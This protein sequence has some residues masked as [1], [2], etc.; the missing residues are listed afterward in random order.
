M[1]GYTKGKILHHLIAMVFLSLITL[2]VAIAQTPGLITKQA[3]G[4]GE[5]ILDPNRD[6][7]VSVNRTGF[8]NGRDEGIGNSEIPYRQ[9]P[10]LTSEPTGDL[11]TGTAGGHTDL[12]GPASPITSPSTGSP[13]A[14][15]FDGTNLLFRVRLGGTSTASKGYSVL[16]DSNNLFDGTGANPGFEFEVL[17]ASN[18]SVQVIDHRGTASGTIFTGAV[19]QYSQRAVAASTNGGNPDFFYDF[20]VPLSAFGGAITATT[21]LRMSGITITSA[22]SGF[23]GTIS[24][25][26]GVNFQAYGYNAPDAWR[27]LL[28]I[29]PPTSLNQI[30]TS[31]IA[32]VA[33]AAPVV[34]SPINAN[35]TTISGTSTEIPGSVVNVLRNGV[36]ICGGTGQPAC[37]TV[38]ANGTWTLSGLSGTLLAAGNTIS[39]TVT[40]PGKT[41]SPLSNVVTV[42]SGICTTTPAPRIVGITG[43]TGTRAI[44][45]APSFTGPQIIRV[46]NL[47]TGSSAVTGVVNLTVGTNYPAS[48]GEAPVA[49]QT[50]NNTNYVVTTTPTDAAGNPTGCESLR[51]NLLCYG[52]G[53]NFTINPHTVT[54]TGVTY[55]GTTATSATN[56]NWS[57]V[58]TNL[59]SVTVNINFGGSNNPGSLVLYRNGIATNVTAPYV[60]GTTTQTLNVT[61]LSPALAPGDLLSIRT[62]LSGSCPALSPASNFLTVSPTLTAPVINEPDCGFVTTLSGTSTNPI[63]TTIQFYTGGTAGTRTG[64]LV[65][66]SDGTTPV[67]ASVTSTG[68]WVA[69]FTS[70]TG[71]GIAAGTPITARAVS[72]GNVS[73]V[74]SNVVIASPGPVGVLT[75]DPITEGATTITG[76]A[77][78]SASGAQITLYIEGTPFPTPVFI[79]GTTWGVEGLSSQDLFSGAT[80]TAT[81]TPPNGCESRLSEPVI[82]TCNP[83]VT[84]FTL[85]PTTTTV[86]GGNTTSFQL[87]GSE[88]GIIYRLLVNGEE[89]GSSVLGTGGPI[90][91]ISGPFTNLTAADVDQTVTYRARRLTGT[92]CDAISPNSVTATV[93]PQ[94][95][96]TNLVLTP[97]T[98]QPVCGSRSVNYSLSGSNP[99]YVYQLVNQLTGLPIGDP[100]P[101]A[102]GN[103]ILTTGPVSSNAT[104]GLQVSFPGADACSVIVP[105]QATVFISGPSVNNFV[106]AANN[107]VCIGNGTTI[108]VQT[109]LNTNSPY[110]YQI[111]RRVG[112]E[113]NFAVDQR[114]GTSFIG[115]NNVVSRQTP[116]LT[117]EGEQLFYV[118]VTSQGCGE[119]L[120]ANTAT[121]LVSN[122]AL[123]ANAGEDQRVCGTS[124]VLSGND[125]GQDA[126]LWSQVSGPSQA[127]FTPASSY[128]ATASNLV[129]GTYTFEWTSTPVCGEGGATT[130]D[131]V[132]IIVNCDAFYTINPPRYNDEYSPGDV[133]AFATDPDGD[134]INAT[135][136]FGSLPNGIAL[137][138]DGT[139]SVT[140]PAALGEGTFPLTIEVTDEFNQT[141]ALSVVIRLLGNEPVIIPLPVELVYFTA[142]VRNNQATLQWLTASELDN[143]R[144]EIERSQDAKS[145]EMVGTVKG[146]GTSNIENKYEFT[147]RTPVQGTVYYRLKQVDFNGEFAY[148]K[149]IAVN[150]KGLSNELTTQVYPNPFPDILKLTLTAPEKQAADMVIYD[151]NGRQVLRKAIELDAGVNSMEL[152]LQQLQSGMYL[153]KIVGEGLESTTKILKN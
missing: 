69:N 19:D 2:P 102:A 129:P 39:A 142:T 116:S 24:D 7:Y 84:A 28:G 83:P 73:S 152:Q 72:T 120:L 100:V 21:P 110:T 51:S 43:T 3:V 86:C 46:Y 133:L 5:Q 47:N 8:V 52:S 113:I 78:A 126:G 148:S 99:A 37:P 10:A 60:V 12:A 56:P 87:S 33:S 6:G 48:S 127:V 139:I 40:A 91:L 123:Q 137:A 34:N 118:T 105:D 125:V 153:L 54:I 85:S 121:V 103:I 106:F 63:G 132:T 128:N 53:N 36:S 80:V 23:T 104:I 101:G 15:Y 112:S 122:A 88:Y 70:T 45:I 68:V 30:R 74:N 29:F 57:N 20:Y 9:F 134:I 26:G 79:S 1:K 108:S 135:I 62:L 131:Q 75:I 25:V 42:T 18:S 16:I 66:Q 82:V 76:T 89:S 151:M 81:F 64:T 146:K 58:P 61:G 111:Y 32:P 109:E 71:G 150:A 140:N 38:S 141:I 55:D 11:N 107:K 92:A 124:V 65:T 41:V 98:P 96:T 77:P 59:T 90:T 136:V 13:I 147:D 17:L 67:T 44:V 119:I 14:V 50:V 143:D 144:F 22:Q 95:A 93:R 138:S 35:S 149:V 145:F 31:G 4:I 114:I 115:N 97:L 94:P 27:A 49:L 117:E 130:S